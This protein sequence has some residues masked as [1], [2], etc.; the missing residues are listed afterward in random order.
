MAAGEYIS[1]Q[2]QNE[3]TH[4]ELEVERHE[5]RHN[6]GRRAG[7]ARPRCT[8]RAG[9]T[10]TSPP[11]V[12]QQLSPRPG[13][14]AADPRAGG[15]RRRPARSCP[16]RGPPRAR[17]SPSFSVGALIPLLPYLF[18]AHAR[19]SY[20]SCSRLGLFAAGAVSSRFTSRGLVFAGTRQLAARGVR[21][22]GDVRHRRALP[23]RTVTLQT[24]RS[25]V[26][27]TDLPGVDLDAL[28]SWLD[29]GHPGL[30]RGELDRRGDRRR[31]IQ[32]HLPHHRRHHDLGAAPA[33]A[34]ARAADRA[35]HG[36]RVP[37]D[38]R[39]GRH[40]RAGCRGRSRCATTQACSAR[41]ST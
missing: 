37:G 26:G 27:M 18:G 1:V 39:S 2:S 8:S 21:R 3:S 10:A 20:R 34:G 29:A 30:R 33:A 14:G 16:A 7:R 12:A 22:G 38:Q 17:R 35:R 23:R 25:S 40:R 36:A 13:P 31:Q 6:A 15:A 11:L 28:A 4:A 24:D 19:S 41:R 5:L 9:S 32:P